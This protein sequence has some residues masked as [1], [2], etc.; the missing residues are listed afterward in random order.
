M[1]NISDAVKTLEQIDKMMRKQITC[2]Q[3]QIRKRV[4]F[5]VFFFLKTV[6]RLIVDGW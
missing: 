1:N 4:V 5:C 3:K 2:T 6:K